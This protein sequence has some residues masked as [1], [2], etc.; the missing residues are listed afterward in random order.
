MLYFDMFV[1]SLPIWAISYKSWTETS[2]NSRL[3]LLFEDPSFLT[4]KASPPPPRLWARSHQPKWRSAPWPRDGLKGI[5]SAGEV[6]CLVCLVGWLE[7]GEKNVKLTNTIVRQVRF[8]GPTKR[9]IPWFFAM[10]RKESGCDK[11]LLYP[12][13]VATLLGL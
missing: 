12:V 5:K 9:R 7:H 6:G 13:T 10:F 1:C 11:C 2:R 4:S 8:P 3:N